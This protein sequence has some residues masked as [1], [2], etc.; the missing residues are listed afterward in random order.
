[1]KQRHVLT[2]MGKQ[3]RFLFGL[4]LDFFLRRTEKY[5]STSIGIQCTIHKI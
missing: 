3:S 2:F 5:E 4:T 1:M